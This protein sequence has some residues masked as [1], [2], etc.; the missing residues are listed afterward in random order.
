MPQEPAPK[1]YEV[2]V[3][4]DP[5]TQGSMRKSKTGNIVHDKAEE[6]TRWR[7]Q[8]EDA[9]CEKYGTPT[10]QP[11]NAAVRVEVIITVTA[12]RALPPNT[13]VF[14]DTKPDVDKLARA[15]GDALAPSPSSKIK[16]GS[17]AGQKH[18]RLLAEDGRIVSWGAQKTY[19]W[20]NHTHRA[21][22]RVP[23]VQV[24]VTVLSGVSV[25]DMRA[26]GYSV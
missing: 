10:W 15:V 14:A 9:F 16:A 8:I 2:A 25:A 6:L 1:I 23:G 4:G 11:I 5:I 26:W 22:L 24:R 17:R 12:R 18:F 21:A 19:P 7:Q 20:G 3:Y 13:P